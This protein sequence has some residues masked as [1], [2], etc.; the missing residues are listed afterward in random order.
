MRSVS[1]T[2]STTSGVSA[3]RLL[4]V[5]ILR[6]WV[7]SLSMR[8]NFPP[9]I[10]AMVATAVGYPRLSSGLCGPEGMRWASTAVN[11]SAVSGRNSWAKPMRLCPTQQRWG[12]RHAK[13]WHVCPPRWN[14]YW[15]ISLTVVASTA[16]RDPRQHDRGEAGIIVEKTHAT[17]LRDLFAADD[18]ALQ[19]VSRARN[20]GSW[21]PSRRSTGRDPPRLPA[22]VTIQAVK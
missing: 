22:G 16:M 15:P 21:P 6:T 13:R 11:S 17:T 18:C 5:C 14:Y 2:A 20:K 8:R 4:S 19:N 10:L 7:S 3:S 12:N 1:L 9:V